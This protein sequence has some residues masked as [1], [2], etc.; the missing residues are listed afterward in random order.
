MIEQGLHIMA[1][2]SRKQLKKIHSDYRILGLH[3]IMEFGRME[4]QLQ[5]IVE[6]QLQRQPL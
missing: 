5:E 1:E 4:R 6:K 2:D 3:R